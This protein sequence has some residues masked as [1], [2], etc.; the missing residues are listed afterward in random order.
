MAFWPLW[1]N[2]EQ[3]SPS[4]V[5]LFFCTHFHFMF[6]LSCTVFS[7]A[8]QFKNTSNEGI[9]KSTHYHLSIF[10]YSTDFTFYHPCSSLKHLIFRTFSLI[11]RALPLEYFIHFH[12]L[13]CYSDDIKT[14][15]SKYPAMSK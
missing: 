1:T 6:T 7:L 8:L 13:K 3:K 9:L 14:L 12:G 4:L 11:L 5:L 10:S 2:K 15:K